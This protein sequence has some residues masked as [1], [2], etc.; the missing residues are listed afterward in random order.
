[1][2]NMEIW[3]ATKRPPK[4]A[5]KTIY[6]GRL[7]GMTDVNPQ[8]RYQALTEQFGPCGIGWKYEIVKLWLEPYESEV[9]AFAL[10]NL[11]I[12]NDNEVDEWSEPI[13]GIGGSMLAVKEKKGIHVTDECFKMAVT[14]ALSVACKALGIAADIYAGRWDGDKYA[15]PQNEGLS[16]EQIAK[17]KSLLEETDSDVEKFLKY[18][19]ADSIEAITDYKM[20]IS[21]LEAKKNLAPD[22]LQLKM[23]RKLA[24]ELGYN[25]EE[26]ERQ[27]KVITKKEASEML[28]KLSEE[29]KRIKPLGNEKN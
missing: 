4:D 24:G 6:G 10:V 29:K 21:A 13:P 18:M 3:E 11:Y 14:D 17:I 5:L 8:W 23:I 7:N 16:D 12:K 19:K 1:M 2:K 25:S 15:E 9:C 20:A 26:V 22:P 27:L 28:K